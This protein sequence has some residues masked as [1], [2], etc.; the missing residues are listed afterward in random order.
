VQHRR[1]L[2][3]HGARV[4]GLVVTLG[5]LGACA[6]CTGEAPSERTGQTPVAATP[7]AARA[8][9]VLQPGK[10]GEP[11][12]TR[13]PDRTVAHAPWNTADVAFVQMMIPHHTQALRMS[14]LARTRA[15]DGAVT[16]V[17]RRIRAAQAPEI[18][19]MSAWLQARGLHD[20]MQEAHGMHHMQGM[21]GTQRMQG[22]RHAR[23]PGMLSPAQM[24][25]LASASGGRFDRLFLAG[26]IRH[27]R[28]AVQMA[29]RAL[30]LGSDTRVNEMAAEVSVEQQAEIDR[31]RAI[32]AA[33]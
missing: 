4:F 10:P 3:R 17:A 16:A 27:H 32:R 20:G 15:D 28:G 21:H 25:E 33:L 18:V 22:R 23:M 26:M 9:T 1:S 6:G 8:G 31:M 30:R 13:P 2:S 11:A 14:E 12:T 24:R 5:V 7:E 29:A 19:A